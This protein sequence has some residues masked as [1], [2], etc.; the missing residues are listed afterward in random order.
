[1]PTQ[2]ELYETMSLLSSRMVEAARAH[3]WDKLIELE[4]DVIC[5][6]STLMTTPEDSDPLAADLAGKHSLI[7]RI[8]E[9]D[10]EVRRHTEPW[11]ERVC[12]FLGDTDRL[13]DLRK[14]CATN[15]G[16]AAA[17]RC[18]A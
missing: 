8:L 2:V 6:R 1:M 14:A 3:D 4:R 15:P 16:E 10:A 7:Q 11:M 12:Q 5:L 9:D 17:D 18:G 13:R